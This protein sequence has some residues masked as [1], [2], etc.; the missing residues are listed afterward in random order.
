M[1]R[2]TIVTRPQ[3]DGTKRYAT[4]IRFNGKQR[5][6]TFGTMKK[7][8]TYLNRHSADIQEG[9]FRELKKGTFKSY[10]D[11]WKKKHLIPEILKPATLNSYGSNIARHLK[12]F[13]DWQ[14]TSIDADEITTFESGLLQSG[15]SP[16]STRNIL[17]LL[18]RI[19]KDAKRDGYLRISPMSDL[20]LTKLDKAESRSLAKNEIG[21]LLEQCPD[22]SM[23]RVVVLL[24][25]LAGL[26]RNEIFALSWE[27]VDAPNN[28]IHV[29]Q[30]LF[31]RHGKY[32][33]ERK[34]DEPAWILHKPKT[35]AS[36]R[37]VDLSPTLKRELQAYYLKSEHKQ[38]LIFQTSNGGPIDPHN[39][40]ERQFKSAIEAGKAKALEQ[41]QK[42]TD[43]LNDVTLHTLRHTF[44]SMKLEHGE[45][46]VYVSKQLGH[47]KLSITA[48]VYSHLCLEERRPEAAVRTD[49]FL[50][51]K[52]PKA[53]R[54]ARAKAVSNRA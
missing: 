35:K 3:K 46:L 54:T 44:G 52:A 53:Q 4:V 51:G 7:A 45:N 33:G 26:R 39:F 6:K 32:Q 31:W 15:Q 9:T 50:F 34:P 37:A 41:D 28:V 22:A 25:L 48:D 8:E 19:L 47:S 42:N 21:Q 1:A 14:L 16:K 36:I 23:L 40:S 5:W 12:H 24:A 20:K 27:D 29:R 11:L 2:G 43:V 49:E 10:V 30:N 17:N 18:H 13:D 38:G